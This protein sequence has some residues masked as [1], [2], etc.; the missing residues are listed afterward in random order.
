MKN[1]FKVFVGAFLLLSLLGC[2]DVNVVSENDKIKDDTKITC[3]VDMRQAPSNITWLD[4]YVVSSSYDTI[5]LYFQPM[6]SGATQYAEVSGL[7]PDWYNVTVNAY[8]NVGAIGYTGSTSTQVTS[9]QTSIVKLKLKKVTTGGIG[10]IVEWDDDTTTKDPVYDSSDVFEFE[11]APL[12]TQWIYE[13]DSFSVITDTLI[14]T[15]DNY[16]TFST[17]LTFN[18]IDTVFTF[19]PVI[20]E[21]NYLLAQESSQFY[22]HYLPMPNGNLVHFFYD[23]GVNVNNG[24]ITWVLKEKI[25]G[26]DTL[27]VD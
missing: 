3:S 7:Y 6:D 8:T 1:M 11:Y 23:D 14:F 9:G 5:Y 25:L 24:Y 12:G 22:S 21:D 10:V 26:N 13:S 19:S 2:D 17:I 4:G 16:N 15:K 20:I 27:V 18:E